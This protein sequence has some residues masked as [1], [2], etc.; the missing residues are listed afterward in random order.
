MPQR[1]NRL[2][3]YI[4]RPRIE[5]KGHG[6][7]SFARPAIRDQN[8]VDRLGMWRK[9]IPQTKRPEQPD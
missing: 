6:R 9:V 1:F 4:E 7:G 2:T 8:V 5:M 3:I